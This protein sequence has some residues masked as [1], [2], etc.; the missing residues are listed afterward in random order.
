M[1]FHALSQV[2]DTAIDSLYNRLQDLMT[3]HSVDYEMSL[4]TAQ[5]SAKCHDLSLN[6]ENNVIA[7][8]LSI[9]YTITHHS[10]HSK[11]PLKKKEGT[12][13]KRLH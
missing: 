6:Q 9:N 5:G 2:Q 3:Y 13:Y 1:S 11:C 8:R 10:V 7:Y 12:D 4:R